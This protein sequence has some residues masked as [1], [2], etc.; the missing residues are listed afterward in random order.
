MSRWLEQLPDG[1]YNETLNSEDECKYLINEVCCND[2]CL[3]MVT[4]FPDDEECSQ[5]RYFEK[6]DLQ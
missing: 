6:E 2:D 3:E 4:E 5:C 1:T